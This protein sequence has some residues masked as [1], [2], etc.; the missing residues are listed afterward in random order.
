MPKKI[1]IKD[2][3]TVAAVK[4]SDVLFKQPSVGSTSGTEEIKLVPKRTPSII[5]G[6]RTDKKETV[7]TK[8]DTSV[9][10]RTKGADLP[11]SSKP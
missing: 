7:A 4:R 1:N 5:D 9:I 8:K 2:T 6:T 3:K 11:T 10:T